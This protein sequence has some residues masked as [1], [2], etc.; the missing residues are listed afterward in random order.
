MG[1]KPIFNLYI[2]CLCPHG[3]ECDF[4]T[5][6]FLFFCSFGPRSAPR[7]YLYNFSVAFNFQY[8]YISMLARYNWVLLTNCVICVTL[9]VT[10]SPLISVL[11]PNIPLFK[12]A[13]HQIGCSC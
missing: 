6:C 8:V 3:S 1:D 12:Q 5:C 11:V 9:T 2:C 4:S 10:Y 13:V 7:A